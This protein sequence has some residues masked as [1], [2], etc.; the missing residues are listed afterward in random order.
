MGAMDNP[1]VVSIVGGIIASVIGGVLLS[2]LRGG[3]ILSKHLAERVFRILIFTVVSMFLVYFL[4]FS[5]PSHRTSGQLGEISLFAR[6][7][8]FLVME[9]FS[10]MA[11]L[12]GREL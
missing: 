7:A 6:L 11:I 4:F 1:W 10:A 12:Y 5:D 8:L 2:F 3:E 9:Y